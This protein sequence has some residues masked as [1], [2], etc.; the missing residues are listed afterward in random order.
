MNLLN[1]GLNK[2][3]A[4]YVVPVYQVFWVCGNVI[5]GM[6]YFQDYKSM[7][8]ASMTMFLF[9]VCVTMMG[10]YFLSQRKSN[11]TINS[12][13]KSSSGPANGKSRILGGPN[14]G[15]DPET[16][17]ME[18]SLIRGRR[19]SSV[20]VAG[21][22]SAEFSQSADG[23]NTISIR[24]GS[25]DSDNRP[26]YAIGDPDSPSPS[27]DDGGAR[28]LHQDGDLKLNNVNELPQI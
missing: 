11:G 21:F 3:D 12:G 17:A 9:G 23:Y 25:Q 10:V 4:L 27:P 13:N 1:M 16:A 22:H 28:H 19:S 2:A 7:D 26:Q 8:A 14:I 18:Q 20:M 24:S 6:M 5:A 15:L